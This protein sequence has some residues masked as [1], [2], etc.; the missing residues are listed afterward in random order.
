MEED[1]IIEELQCSPRGCVN[2][3]PT[4]Q[5]LYGDGESGTCYISNSS[6]GRRRETCNL[7]EHFNLDHVTSAK[8]P[9]PESKPNHP[10]YK[11]AMDK[12]NIELEECVT[13]QD[14]RS[15]V[16]SAVNAGIACVGSYYSKDQREQVDQLLLD[17]GCKVVMHGQSDS[18]ELECS[19]MASRR[20]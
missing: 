19:E 15:V 12:L 20:L 14:L 4:L 1:A 18:S 3:V 6:C 11:W 13:V 17:S 10:V 2:A 7:M 8:K 5:K 9:T 16:Q